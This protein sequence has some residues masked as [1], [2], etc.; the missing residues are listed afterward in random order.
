[1]GMI[2]LITGNRSYPTVQRSPSAAARLCSAAYRPCPGWRRRAEQRRGAAHG[3]RPGRCRR[4]ARAAPLRQ[5]AA[6]ADSRVAALQGYEAGVGGRRDG[7]H[8]CGAER[9]PG[10][11][12]DL[13]IGEGRG[14]VGVVLDAIGVEHLSERH[15]VDGPSQRR[16]PREAHEGVGPP[17]L[18]ARRVGVGANLE[19]T[20]PVRTQHRVGEARTMVADHG[21]CVGKDSNGLGHRLVASVDVYLAASGGA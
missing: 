9:H 18:L 5:W 1:M 6:R 8:L 15:A 7:A 13:L 16:V 20:R 3:G 11:T 4:A 17:Q 12:L 2:T 21:P 19:D 14:A 10:E